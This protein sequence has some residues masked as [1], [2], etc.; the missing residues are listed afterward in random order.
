MMMC[1]RKICWLVAVSISVSGACLYAAEEPDDTPLTVNSALEESIRLRSEVDR[2]QAQIA[3]QELQYGPYDRSLVEALWGL[4]ETLVQLQ[5]FD[6][7][8]ANLGRL[9][10][11]LRTLDGPNSLAQVSVLREA[12]RNDISR[13]DWES[14][15]QRFSYLQHLYSQ[16]DGAP[17]LLLE[18]RDQLIRW[19]LAALYLDDPGKRVRHFTEAMEL[20]RQNL[21]LATDTFGDESEAMIPWLYR[22]AVQK[23]QVY[24]ILNASDELGLDAR[25]ALIGDYLMN[26]GLKQVQRYVQSPVAGR[27]PRDYLSAELDR[28]LLDGLGL[29]QRIR[30]IVA[31]GGDPEAEAMAIIYEADFQ[32]LLERRSAAR[33]YREAM[34]KLVDAGVSR[35]RVDQFFSRPAPLPEPAFH[36]SLGEAVNAQNDRGVVPAGVDSLAHLGRYEAWNESLAAARRPPLP[37]AATE[38]AG[39]VA[40]SEFEI[41]FRLNSRGES[42][43]RKIVASG[44]DNPRLRSEAIDALELIRFRPVFESRRPVSVDNL[45]ITYSIPGKP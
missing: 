33:I 23:Y 26:E 4:N 37:D 34:D 19:H 43:N 38:A 31:T 9:L 11:L 10:M 40:M 5:A 35:S 36:A 28:A 39:Q 7:A 8:D 18:A 15:T 32:L 6:E 42:R 45:L 1:A 27:G 24:S 3:G 22:S 29:V 41:R 12:I 20:Q 17:E 14:V 2:Y 30:N 13:R 44:V 21:S 16:V 25:R